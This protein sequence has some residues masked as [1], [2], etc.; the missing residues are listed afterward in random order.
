VT[1][2]VLP[3]QSRVPASKLAEALC[4]TVANLGIANPEAIAA[5]HLTASV[6]VVTGRAD[7]GAGRIKLLTRAITA[8]SE[9]AA[10][11]GDRVVRQCA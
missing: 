4:A 1:V 9:I 10:G 6:A 2:I 11:G 8:V 3:N 7:G 5:K